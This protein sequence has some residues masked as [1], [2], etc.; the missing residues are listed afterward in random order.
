VLELAVRVAGEDGPD[1][2][3]SRAEYA[4][5]IESLA[6]TLPEALA[7]LF[8]DAHASV[9]PI[10]RPAHPAHKV[11]AS[12]GSAPTSATEA[13]WRRLAEITRDL[14]T[15][16]RLRPLLERLMDA[17]VE[18]S[19]AAR[20]FI[21]LEGPDHQLRV[22]TARNIGRRDL[23][24][25]EMA[26][27]R[28]VA[29]RV[30]RSGE[31]LITVDATSDRRLDAF[32]SVHSMRLRSILCV[33]L[34]VQGKVVG[35]VYVDDRFRTG[36]FGDDALEVAREFAEAAA[37]AIHNARQSAELRRALRK[38]ERLSGELKKR[39]DAQ[40]VELEATRRA[41][42]GAPE[43][44]GH[45]DGIV[46]RGPAMA[47]TLSLLDK[48]APTSMPVLLLGESGTGKEL[49]ARAVH[50]NSP[51]TGHAFVAEN[52]GAIPETL[53]ESVLFGHVKGAFTG[54]DRTRA[55]LF[56]V[57]NGGTLFLDEIGEMSPTMQA[58][59]LR[60][61]QDGE[62]R[63][64]GDQRSRKV[65]VRVIAATH[66]DLAE[67]V[68]SGRFREDLYYR[69][70]VMV[71][72]V[73]ALRQRREDLPPLVAHFVEKHARRAI[74]VER[75]AMARL[76]AHSWPGNVRELENE[77]MRACVLAE[78]AVREDDLSPA[79]LEGGAASA[80][81]RVVAES[82]ASGS[83]G[84]RAAIEAVERQLIQRALEANGGNQSR[85]ARALG[86]SRFGL[87]KKLKR[88]AGQAATD[89]TDEIDDEDG[90]ALASDARAARS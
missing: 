1:G 20:G 33:P 35:T 17:V 55:G 81:D 15:E 69:L 14:N 11:D 58:K 53:L 77:I 90:D 2:S 13:R 82:L 44:R 89:P 31:A 67:M 8:R 18:L 4:A 65:D 36:A 37:V 78:G 5:R 79:V 84:L 28:S 25:D 72:P 3:R 75:K 60:V 63:P 7:T 27:S 86:L 85:A 71:I 80:S 10:A 73:P 54:A 38:A 56:E 42:A 62:V 64:L 88:L 39:V 68:R 22:R 52:C 61:L 19:G 34:A 76:V 50:A 45:Y 74:G 47:R 59:L 66:R 24:G 6:A 49:L 16:Q 51:R 46:G 83:L 43:T 21:L 87:Q 9:A 41:L 30:A 26:V 57:A 29:E 23:A 12:T 32:E 70:A 48:V 40:T